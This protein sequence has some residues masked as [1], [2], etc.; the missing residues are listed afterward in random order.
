MWFLEKVKKRQSLFKGTVKKS[1][2]HHDDWSSAVSVLLF[3]RGL[4]RKRCQFFE[5]VQSGQFSWS[6]EEHSEVFRSVIMTPCDLG[7]ATQPWDISRQVGKGSA[8]RFCSGWSFRVAELVTGEFFEQGDRERAELK[9]TPASGQEGGQREVNNLSHGGPEWKQWA[10]DWFRRRAFSNPLLVTLTLSAAKPTPRNIIEIKQIG[11]TAPLTAT[12]RRRIMR[13]KQN[14]KH[15]KAEETAVVQEFVVEKIIQRRVVDGKVEYFLKWKGFTDADNTWEPEDN[16]DCPELIE[17]FLRTLPGR[18]DPGEEDLGL[19]QVTRLEESAE[20]DGQQT[21]RQPVDEPLQGVQDPGEQQV[22]CPA[23]LVPQYEPER[24]IGSTDRQGELMFLVK[25]KGT[26]E[27]ALLSAR[28]ASARCPQVVIAFYEE[29]LAWN[30]G[31]EEQQLPTQSVTA[32]RGRGRARAH[33]CTHPVSGTRLQLALRP[34]LAPHG[35]V[36]RPAFGRRPRIRQS[37]CSASE[38]TITSQFPF[39]TDWESLQA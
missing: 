24:I 38:A 2:V 14:V 35:S 22:R 25:W 21:R 1:E 26:E 13:K 32:R 11:S 6:N 7:A 8:S 39:S 19:P 12:Y 33:A 16:L 10:T 3:P 31:E 34:P 18:G 4:W 17:E 27:V 37:N 23:G 20:P 29:K 30:S 5:C 36:S 15:R 28:E 9:L